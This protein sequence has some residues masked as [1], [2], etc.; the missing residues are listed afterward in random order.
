MLQLILALTRACLHPREQKVSLSSSRWAQ[1]PSAAD[2]QVDRALRA[3]FLDKV[4]CRRLHV[5]DAAGST[6]RSGL[7]RCSPSWV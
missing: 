1:P 4:P 2:W 3:T 5:R 7:A 6:S